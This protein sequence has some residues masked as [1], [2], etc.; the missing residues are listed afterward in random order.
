MR[1]SP[2]APYQKA[3]QRSLSPAARKPAASCGRWSI[4]HSSSQTRSAARRIDDACNWSSYNMLHLFI[5][6]C[7][8]RRKPEQH[9]VSGVRRTGQLCA[10]AVLED[11]SIGEHHDLI[12]ALNSREPVRDDDAGAVLKQPIDGLC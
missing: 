6:A 3:R 2:P 10:P 12:D 5:E 7:E 11:A 1:C 8:F 9:A 4:S